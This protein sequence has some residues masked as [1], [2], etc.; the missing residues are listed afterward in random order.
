MPERPNIVFLMSD[1]Q[2]AA[3]TSVYGNNH[4][5]TPFMTQMARE[6][7]AFDQAYA[8]SAI[9]TPSRASMMT[10]V[11]PLVHQVTCHQNRAP[12]NLPQ[13]PE[14]TAA[15]GYYNIAA[16]HYES[17]RNL[18][19]GWHD[20]L[21]SDDR[22]TIHDAVIK[23]Q[24]AGRADVGWSSGPIDC[25]VEQSADSLLTDRVEL[26]LDTAT[27]VKAPFFLHVPYS[28][29]HPP[30]CAPPPYD[31]MIDP[32]TLPLPRQHGQNP[33]GR[34]KWQQQC[35]LECATAR[36][37]DDDIRKVVAVYY[38]MIALVDAQMRRVYDALGRRG[39]LE[40][41]WI[42][43]ASDHGDF[44]GE[45]GLFN[46][47]ELLY[48]CLLHVP[49]IIR[50]P[51]GFNAPRGVHIDGLV[52]LIDLFPTIAKL[53][54]AEAPE[55][56]QGSD[57]VQWVADGA[58]EPL[59]DCLFAQ[60]GQYH[61]HLKTTFPGGI[62]E[63]GRRACL[64]QGARTSTFSYIRD[65]DWGD[66]AYDLRADPL[67]LDNLLNPGCSAPPYEVDALRRRVDAFEA[68]CLELRERLG[69]VPGFD[70]FEPKW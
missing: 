5:S 42:I 58:D 27:R 4:V 12:W 26:M 22:G 59:H 50:P 13:L 55:Y 48:E 66:E 51:D 54:G 60:A 49:L 65:A 16:G 3:A 24:E 31:T 18:S 41:T 67:E 37:T 34:P 6:G 53:A 62:P 52:N 21:S 70:G 57:L 61:G 2:K 46:K 64:V 11:H 23:W 45:K 8:A 43:I 69:V 29:P 1:Q 10:G 35:L 68:E 7:I 63:S 56:T 47:G 32:G 30:Y 36:A 15:A 39:M 28:Q 14:L 9:C 25:T 40:N 38:G 33:K 20:H 17:T 44:T 19:R